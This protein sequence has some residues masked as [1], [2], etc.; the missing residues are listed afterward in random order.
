MQQP[1]YTEHFNQLVATCLER[2]V[3]VQTIKSIAYRPWMGRPGL[4]VAVQATLFFNAFIAHLLQSLSIR[5]YTEGGDSGFAADSLFGA[6]VRSRL[7][8]MIAREEGVS[9]DQ[10]TACCYGR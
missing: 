1:Y 10:R 9:P 7:D 3:A 5:L 6:P 4:L 8:H 2:N